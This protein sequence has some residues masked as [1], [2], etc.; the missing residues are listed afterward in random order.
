MEIERL[1]QDCEELR[2]E[3][4]ATRVQI[5]EMQDLGREMIARHNHQVELLEGT[6]SDVLVYIYFISVCLYFLILH[7]SNCSLSNST[8]LH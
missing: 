2:E 7:V 4:E 8:I 1:T 3:L 5:N 6:A